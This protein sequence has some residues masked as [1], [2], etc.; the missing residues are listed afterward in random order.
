[1]L[2]HHGFRSA[3]VAQLTWRVMWWASV[4]TGRPSHGPFELLQWHRPRE[5]AQREQPH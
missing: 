3:S 5:G 2:R 1:L 4:C